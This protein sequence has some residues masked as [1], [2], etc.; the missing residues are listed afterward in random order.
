MLGQ[1]SKYFGFVLGLLLYVGIGLIDTFWTP[2]L[3]TE[4]TKLG[5][6]LSTIGSITSANNFAN[7]L[8]CFIFLLSGLSAPRKSTLCLGAFIMGTTC[9]I[10]GQLPSLLTKFN[11]LISSLV[12]RFVM[13]IGFSFLW[14][15]GSPIL[16]SI[17]PEN[18]GIVMSSIVI[19][20]G[21][22]VIFGAPL[23]SMLYSYG[24]YSL[25]FTVFGCCQI[26]VSLFCYF[27]LKENSGAGI[28]KPRRRTNSDLSSSLR[29]LQYFMSDFGLVSVC[30]GATAVATAY[31][32][33]AIS[34]AP[35]LRNQY[36]VN[37]EK[38]GRYFLS[39]TVTRT[40]FAL[41]F[42]YLSDKG[43]SVVIYIFCGCFLSALSYA[44]M[45]LG[46]IVSIFNTVTAF[47]VFQAINGIGSVGAFVP[48]INVLSSISRHKN[49]EIETLVSQYAFLFYFLCFASG[50]LF[51][52][53]ILGGFILENCGF[54][55][56]CLIESVIS[57]FAGLLPAVY[58]I[59]KQK[60]KYE[61]KFDNEE[62]VC[63]ANCEP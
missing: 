51:G 46:Q 26:I 36:N 18:T 3:S 27:G 28:N 32:F 33:L 44:L 1:V 5:F 24:G 15:S 29:S 61:A 35:H 43:Y 45:G 34:V 11:L 20:Q 38:A 50:N 55:N 16:V 37:S 4:L 8:C 42:G 58:L 25:P 63:F 12:A 14:C 22:G 9:I 31:S 47:E 57:S 54:Y 40:I 49:S 48:F 39:F 13:G 52:S 19:S 53:Y 21:T 60:Q 10:F 59:M 6:S 56:A 30:I 41:L 7:I 62:I 2:Y 17:F 23:G